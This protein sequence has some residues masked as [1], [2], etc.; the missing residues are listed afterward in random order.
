[1]RSE[2]ER[3]HRLS[4]EGVRAKSEGQ[5]PIFG[6][7][8]LD[9]QWYVHNCLFTV[10]NDTFRLP[11]FAGAMPLPTNNKTRFSE[12]PMPDRGNVWFQLFPLMT[13]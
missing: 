11:D 10:Y 8:D 1:M 13:C 7:G 4:K 2:Q 3:V 6:S 12:A 5:Q 9:G